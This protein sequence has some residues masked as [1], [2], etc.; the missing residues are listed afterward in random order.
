M[1]I[2]NFMVAT[3]LVSAGLA[4]RAD[5]FSFSFGNSSTF[6][7]GSGILTTGSLQAPGEYS[8]ASVTGSATTVSN[9]PSSLIQSILAPGVFPTPSNGGTFPANDN[10]LFVTNNSGSLDGYGLAFILSDGAQINLY[11]PQGSLY[12]ALLER[13]DG[14]VVFADLPTTITALAPVPEPSSF[15]LLGTGLLSVVSAVKRRIL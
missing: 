7:S 12:D 13:A 3:A 4:A 15:L 9:G 1:R 11:D 10:V 6:F 2:R 8:I 14:S 5:S